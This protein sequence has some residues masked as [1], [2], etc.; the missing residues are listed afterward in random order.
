MQLVQ[1]LCR[2][3]KID[4]F[5]TADLIF[6]RDVSRMCLSDDMTEHDTLQASSNGLLH[7]LMQ[8]AAPPD[9]SS[10]DVT[11]AQQLSQQAVSARSS[12]GFTRFLG[13]A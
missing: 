10:A 6:V 2:D 11:Q 5:S 7:A 12:E 1:K 13:A 9:T 3:G 4:C 8:R